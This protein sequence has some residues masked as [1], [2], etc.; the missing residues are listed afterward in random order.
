MPQVKFKY[1]DEAC[2]YPKLLQAVYALCTAKGKDALCTS[3][4]RSIEY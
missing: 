3:A 1:Q 4:Y 2:V